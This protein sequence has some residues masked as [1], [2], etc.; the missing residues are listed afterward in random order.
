MWGMPSERISLQTQRYYQ[1]LLRCLRKVS[2][3]KEGKKA[4]FR[5]RQ[6]ARLC[7][8]EGCVQNYLRASGKRRGQYFLICFSIS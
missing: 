2:S 3:D 8:F 6:T 5:T 7:A 1:S 4:G